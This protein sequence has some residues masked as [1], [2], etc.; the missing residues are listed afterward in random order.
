LKKNKLKILAAGDIHGDTRLAKKLSEKAKKE[1]VDLVVL[2]GD[3]T[4]AESSTSGIIHPFVKN[5]QKVILIPGNH[6]TIATAN[7]LADM[8][9]VTNLHGYSIQI[10]DIGIF[11]CGSAEIGPFPIKDSD[12]FKILKKGSN[13]VK[14]SKKKIM[15]THVHPEKTLMAQLSTFVQGSKAVRKAIKELKPDF[16]F[17]SHV[18]EAEGIEEKIGK[19]KV[20]NVGREGKIIEI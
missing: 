10:D 3:L 5:K 1:N 7:F 18:H 9:G 14:N 2:C 15:V 17:C 11:G 8:Y 19:T 4:Y 13:K 12:I 6:E 16:L 20:I